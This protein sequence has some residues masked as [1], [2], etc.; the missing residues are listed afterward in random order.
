[1]HLK[2]RCKM[3]TR[4]KNKFDVTTK[5]CSL[6]DNATDEKGSVAYSTFMNEDFEYSNDYIIPFHAI[7]EVKVKLSQETEEIEDPTCQNG[8][9]PTPGEPHIDGAT[10]TSIRQG[11]DFDLT[12]GVTAYDGDGNEIPF[13]VTPSEVDKCEVGVQTFTYEAEGVTKERKI[14]V[15]Q[16]ANPTISGLSE[17]T[18]EVNEEFDPLDGV[19]GEDGNGNPVEVTYE[20][21]E[22]ELPLL[23]SVSNITITYGRPVNIP[24]TNPSALYDG[25]VLA[26]SAI[27]TEGGQ[28]LNWRDVTKEAYDLDEY[29]SYQIADTILWSTSTDAYFTLNLSPTEGVPTSAEVRLISERDPEEYP[30]EVTIEKLEVRIA[31]RGK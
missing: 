12:E 27:A 17:L 16:I 19:T 1:M 4:T 30:A 5:A 11:T 22:E 10:N 15:T 7:C 3:I 28:P 18:V 26:L 13:T 6:T 20:S 21:G 29:Y 8:D 9:E 25:N 24:I 2:E 23:T 14:T 31:S